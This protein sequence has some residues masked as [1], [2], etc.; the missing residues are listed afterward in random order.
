[1]KDG[2]TVHGESQWLLAASGD[3]ANELLARCPR[4]LLG[5]LAGGPDTWSLQEDRDCFTLGRFV[6]GNAPNTRWV[7]QVH[8]P[9]GHHTWVHRPGEHMYSSTQIASTQIACR[10]GALHPHV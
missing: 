5:A 1:M 10:Q 7:V 4:D 2:D 8:W 9:C 6:P 3:P